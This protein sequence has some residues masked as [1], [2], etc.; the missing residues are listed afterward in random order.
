MSFENKRSILRVS[1]EKISNIINNNH[2][3]PSI[4]RTENTVSIKLE[5]ELGR[6]KTSIK[7]NNLGKNLY[8]DY[9]GKYKDKEFIVAGCG[10]SIKNYNDFSKYYIIGVNDI[11]R[12]L[13]PDFLL[14]VNEIRTFT[15]GRWEYVNKS[16]SPVIFSHLNPPGPIE[17]K[18]NLVSLKLGE[19]YG[20]NLEKMDSV[21]FTM[22]SPYM[23]V[24]IAYQLGAKKIGLV[25]VD[26]TQD[27]FFSKS[28][29]HKLSKGINDIDKQY[30][31]LRIALERKG[32]KVANLSEISLLRSWPKMTLEEFDKL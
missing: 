25:G 2:N 16:M 21:D 8:P 3:T 13:T 32:I 17:R 10:T 5:D 31:D 26:F 11:E 14:V 30:G 28:G 1:R 27:H 20:T 19:R 29:E 4:N 6:I 18:E 9:I 15:R 22:N 24:I 12:I 23:G 7:T